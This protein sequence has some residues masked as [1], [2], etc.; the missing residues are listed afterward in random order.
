M[1]KVFNITEEGLSKITMEAPQITNYIMVSKGELSNAD[2]AEHLDIDY[3]D[4]GKTFE[5]NTLVFAKFNGNLD[6]GMSS[7]FGETVVGWDLYKRE[8]GSSYLRYVGFVSLLYNSITDYFVRNNME[9]TYFLY[10][11]GE[12]VIGTPI[13]S[14][15]V[16]SG[17]WNWVILTATPTSDNENVLAVTGAYIF[18]GNVST[19]KISNNS[20]GADA[21]NFTPYPK[22]TKGHANYKSGTLSGL[23]G[24]VDTRTNEYVE[25]LDMRDALLQLSTS[26]ERMFLKSRSGDIWEIAIYNAISL[27]IADSSIRQQ[28]TA[29]VDWAEIA[30]TSGISLVEGGGN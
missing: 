16:T 4:I 21:K 9:Y 17:I 25:T 12:S 24:Y 29:N 6:A 8:K 20:A 13:L 18:Q 28:N 2:K 19:S 14:D 26:N 11:R 3:S 10:P 23:I 15:P 1:G 30:S 7:S 22:I 5:A 27:D